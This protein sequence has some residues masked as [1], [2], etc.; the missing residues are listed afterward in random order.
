MK[1]WMRWLVSMMLVVISIGQAWAIKHEVG[2]RRV[3]AETIR[4]EIGP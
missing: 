2:P 4:Q 3:A 1:H